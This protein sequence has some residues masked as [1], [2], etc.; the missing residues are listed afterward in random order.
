MDI[1]TFRQLA[2]ETL[3][4]LTNWPIH[5]VDRYKFLD[6]PQTGSYTTGHISDELY[7]R[8][9]KA[10]NTG[11]VRITEQCRQLIGELIY[12]EIL[13]NLPIEP[14]IELLAKIHD[15]TNHAQTV[16]GDTKEEWRIAI[17]LTHLSVQIM[18]LKAAEHSKRSYANYYALAYASSRLRSIGCFVERNGSKLTINA[19]TEIKLLQKIEEMIALM[20][21]LYVARHIFGVIANQY[22]PKFER[23]HF[24]SQ[25]SIHEPQPPLIPWG[26]LLQLSVKHYNRGQSWAIPSD[27]NLNFLI[28]LSRDYA[29][30]I[31]AQDYAYFP[32][33]HYLPLK[34]MESV[35]KLAVSDSLYKI[36]QVRGSDVPRILRGL[37][38]DTFLDLPFEKGWTIRQAVEVIEAILSCDSYR[39]PLPMLVS[40]D[41]Q[42]L[43]P[44]I[45]A[46]VIDVILSEVLSHSILG[47][48]QNL[49]RPTDA[50]SVEVCED[51]SQRPLLKHGEESYVMIDRSWCAGAFIEALFIQM[52][53]KDK[54]LDKKYLGE[55]I[56]RFTKEA[57]VQHNIQ[58]RCGKYLALLW[59]IIEFCYFLGF[60][61]RLLTD[62]WVVGIDEADHGAPAIGLDRR[63]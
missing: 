15:A 26:F 60:P 1:S 22:D 56:E 49:S 24:V 52:R 62:S 47:A 40:S 53:D 20:G 42:R 3:P 37:I 33:L 54:T 63:A 23:H 35:Q 41:V 11:N 55:A 7:A 17:E 29:T 31:E 13:D 25:K 10:F 9:R 44:T 18:S 16:G 51:F 45:K 14:Y 48:N 6:L 59:H 46:E 30:F 2:D 36:P 12:D 57:L 50:S 19:E 34:M 27:D 4:I 39:I 21:G 58:P 61:N 28:A 43:C 8:I 5:V 38:D 32:H